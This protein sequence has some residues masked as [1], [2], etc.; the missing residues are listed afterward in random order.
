MILPVYIFSYWIFAW[1]LLYKLKLVESSP[2]LL[3]LLSSAFNI[4]TAVLLLLYRAPL[5]NVI[6]LFIVTC[7]TKLL[8]LYD[9]RNTRIHASE[10]FYLLVVYSCFM[11]LNDKGIIDVYRRLFDSFRTLDPTDLS[12]AGNLLIRSLK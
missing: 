10:S 8:P 1:Y 4:L 11:R 7:I 6:V 5:A 3:L 9:V 12:I 2:L